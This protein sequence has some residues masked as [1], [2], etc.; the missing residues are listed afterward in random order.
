[1]LTPARLKP[2]YLALA[3]LSIAASTAFADS[4]I[5]FTVSVRGTGSASIHAHIYD[6]PSGKG[7]TTILAVHGLTGTASIWSPLAGAV[8]ADSTLN[9][10]VKRVIAIDHI[11]HGESSL[12]TLPAGTKFGDLLIEDYVSTVIQSIDYLRSHNLGAQVLLGHSMGGLEIQAA[13]EQLLASNSS[14]AKHGIAG[15]ILISPVPN[16]NSVWTQSPP[17]DVSPYLKTTPELGTY[18]E[19]TPV[20]AQ[21]GATWRNL[22]GQVVSNAPS[23]QTIQQNDWIGIEPI[24]VLVE[25]TSTSGQLQRPAARNGAFQKSNGTLLAIISESQ[26][27]LTPAVDQDDL[28]LQLTGQTGPLYRQVVAADAVHG[29]LIS[30]PNGIISSIRNSVF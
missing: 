29:Q 11:G 12:P 15:A 2:L 21:Q 27:I 19:L 22:Q 10:A 8:F 13:Q 26:D 18:L 25:L 30:N 17:A 24:N 14:L 3:F 28:Y 4:D 23:P 6:N 20:A 7:A 5:D 9:K 16:R 1:M